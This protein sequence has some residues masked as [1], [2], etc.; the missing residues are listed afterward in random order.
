MIR[1]TTEALEKYFLILSAIEDNLAEFKK[2]KE[3]LSVIVQEVYSS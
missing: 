2:I 1:P 3:Q